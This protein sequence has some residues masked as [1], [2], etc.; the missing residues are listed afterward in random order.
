MGDTA[1]TG[2]LTEAIVEL[3]PHL[4]A[5]WR[6]DTPD[7]RPADR[8]DWLS[9][10]D[11]PLPDVGVGVEQVV[12]ELARLVVPYGPR[13]GKP[14]FSGF[15]VNGPTTTGVVANLA[16]TAA[17]P[18]RYLLT[19]PNHLEAMSLQWLQSLFG[20]PARY[21]GVYSTGGSV[22]N[23]VALGAARQAAYEARGVDPAADGIDGPGRVY[24]SVEA[25]N[26]IARSAAVLG[27]G[28]HAVH[29]IPVD[30]HQ[31]IDVDAVARAIAADREAGILPVA[32]VGTAGTTNTGAIDPL[33]ELADLAGSTDVWFHVDGAYGLLAAA[34]PELAP[35]FAAVARADSVIVDPHK[36]LCTPIG[37]GATFVRDRRLLHRAFTEGPADYLE[38]TFA[39][40]SAESM[41]DDMG[42]PYADYGVELTAPARGMVVWALLRELGLEG[43]QATVRRD[44]GFARRLADR[45]R[46]EPR[47][48]LMAEPELSIVCFRFVPPGD[49]PAADLDEINAEV[50]RR[51]RRDT[52]YAPSST[53]V[54][55]RYVIRP[56]YINPR[57]TEADVD[58][59]ADAVL[60]IGAE[61]TS[62]S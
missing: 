12:D 3:L 59:L 7:P 31:R 39:P 17:S 33:D 22:A 55:G 56:C 8:G 13:V 46:A 32:I 36:W 47:L 1:E 50:L 42:A 18:H 40:E 28:R 38:G 54:A 4:E 51:L 44:L 24:A 9:E 45:V 14:G 10:L 21:Q 6:W 19:A 25:H 62:G 11:G 52:P 34:V 23:L 48:E 29:P 5:V 57:T 53:R 16:A 37:I 30:D 41:F 26:T 35:R 20:V 49:H 2:R 58:G 43:V 27:L 61:L 15:I 60:A